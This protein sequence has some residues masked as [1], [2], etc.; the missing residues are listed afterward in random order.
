MAVAT[1][2]SLQGPV[3]FAG[4][5]GVVDENTLE[6][7]SRPGTGFPLPPLVLPIEPVTPPVVEV[8]VV[9][10]VT[11]PVVEVPVV[12]SVTPP[13]VDVPVVESI[14]TPV[15]DTPV[16]GGA[17]PAGNAQEGTGELAVVAQP[18]ASHESFSA[19]VPWVSGGSGVTLGG[20]ARSLG[21]LDAAGQYQAAGYIRSIIANPAVPEGDKMLFLN[22]L[23]R[24]D[25]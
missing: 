13:A 1:G 3:C 20:L 23:Q 19:F 24:L 12:E 2:F 18:H 6:I 16:D 5:L 25:Q 17:V 8:P 21:S 11:P 22:V 7:P 10:P 14:D 4:Q 15:V 9:E